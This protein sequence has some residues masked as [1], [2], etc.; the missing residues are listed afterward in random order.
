MR[1]ENEKESI[2]FLLNINLSPCE[3]LIEKS[4]CVN[5]III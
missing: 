3:K 4:Y 1:T 5:K 2:F